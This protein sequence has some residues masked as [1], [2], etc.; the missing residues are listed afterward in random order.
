[1]VCC[2]RWKGLVHSKVSFAFR[3][4]TQVLMSIQPEATVSSVSMA[5]TRVPVVQ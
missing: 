4:R 1:M 5:M 3:V 2:A